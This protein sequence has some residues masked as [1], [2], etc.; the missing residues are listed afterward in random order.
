MERKRAPFGTHICSVLYPT[1]EN[2]TLQHSPKYAEHTFANGSLHCRRDNS[3]NQ[4][5]N[6]YTQTQFLLFRA[7]IFST[8]DDHQRQYRIDSR[9]YIHTEWKVQSNLDIRESR[10]KGIS[11]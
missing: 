1:L 10:Y 3:R 2:Y 8:G 7:K 4:G 9:I 11:I 5:G 6:Q